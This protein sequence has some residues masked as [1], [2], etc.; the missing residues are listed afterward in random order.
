MPHQCLKCGKVFKKGST[1]LLK[2]CPECGGKKFFYT[3]HPL[4]KEERKKLVDKTEMEIESIAKIIE[5]RGKEEEWVHI[6]P[7]TIKE[8]IKEI[9][10]RKKAVSREM[11]EEKGTVESIS[12]KEVGE[13]T[14][15]LR[16]LL[17]EE[18]IIIQKDGSYLIHLPSLFDRREK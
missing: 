18:S 9:E 12:V 6:E 3:Q 7:K 5:D 2:G 13:Y 10:E 8:I 14:I 4:S 17:D 16:K 1:Q 11:E 15:N